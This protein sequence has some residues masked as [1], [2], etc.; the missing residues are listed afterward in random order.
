GQRS[1]LY[2]APGGQVPADLPRG[3]E[4]IDFEQGYGF[5][6]EPL[7]TTGART[8]LIIYAH[9]NSELALWSLDAFDEPLKRGFAVLIV[10]YPGYG[11][12][13]G[14]PSYESIGGTILAA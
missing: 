6:L 13:P 10:E 7:A 4:R 9:G 3:V 5:L 2:P 8:P 11:G 12:A 1:F 14:A